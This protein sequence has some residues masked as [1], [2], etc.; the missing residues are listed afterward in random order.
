MGVINV[1]EMGAKKA[2][3]RRR[4]LNWVLK[5]ERKLTRLSG[6]LVHYKQR[7]QQARGNDAQKCMTCFKNSL[8][9]PQ[10]A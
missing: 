5:Y 7:V 3:H 1:T 6:N 9:E 4:Y 2:F 10:S 8:T